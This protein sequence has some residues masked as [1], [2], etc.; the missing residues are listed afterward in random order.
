MKE[1][2]R[3]KDARPRRRS[4]VAR[5]GSEAGMDRAIGALLGEGIARGPGVFK[6]GASGVLALAL[7][8]ALAGGRGAPGVE[9]R[10]ERTRG[11]RVRRR[12][13]DARMRG[14]RGATQWRGGRGRRKQS[15]TKRGD[16]YAGGLEEAVPGVPTPALAPPLFLPPLVVVAAAPPLRPASF[17]SSGDEEL[18]CS[19]APAAAA[20]GALGAKESCVCC[21]GAKAR[22]GLMS[23]GARLLW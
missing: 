2:A 11:R 19:P 4:T 20:R 14:R 23:K 16:T 17:N 13:L 1:A 21:N 7:A 8:P 9:I 12:R 15:K 3:C 6:C 22:V 18:S 5:G 10:S